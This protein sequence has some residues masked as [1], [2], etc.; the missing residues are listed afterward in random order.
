[1]CSG[2]IRP[3]GSGR[4]RRST[5]FIVAGG[6][7]G[8]G[9]CCCPASGLEGAAFGAAAAKLNLNVPGRY[10]FAAS[11]PDMRRPRPLHDPDSPELDDDGSGQ[12]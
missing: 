7:R 6:P 9:R 2:G 8:T 3:S 4:G 1:M 11:V 12:E 10:N 5:S